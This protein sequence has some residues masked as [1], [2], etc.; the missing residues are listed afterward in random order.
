MNPLSL[1]WHLP[2]LA[3]ILIAAIRLSVIDWRTRLLPRRIIHTAAALGL[4]WLALASVLAGDHRSLLTMIGGAAWGLI[5]FGTAHL[6]TGGSFGLGDVRL[7]TLLGA[8]LGWIH[9][10]AAPLGL[11]AGLILAGVWGL[12][13]ILAGRA[14]ATDSLA[15]GPFLCAGAALIAGLGV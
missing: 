4:P 3:V 12:G 1:G 13:S 8:V 11:L 14:R 15:L 6:L 10:L 5:G 7:A 2:G 9:P